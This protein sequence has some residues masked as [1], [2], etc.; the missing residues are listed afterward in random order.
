MNTDTHRATIFIGSSSEGGDIA[1]QLEHEAYD[2]C[3]VKKWNAGKVFTPGRST[4][5]SLVEASRE[6]DFAVLVATP[7]DVTEKRG[8]TQAS[9]RDNILL[10]YGLFVGALGRDRA[11]LLVTGEASLPTD[12]LGV[13]TLPW[14]PTRDDDHHAALTGTIIELKKLVKNPGPLRRG[15]ETKIFNPHRGFSF[16][17]AQPLGSSVKNPVDPNEFREILT[18]ELDLLKTSAEEQGWIV[19]KNSETTLRLESPRGKTYTLAK[20]TPEKTRDD[21]RGFVAG[22]RSDGLR[23]SGALRRPVAQ[24]PLHGS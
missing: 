23:I 19:R 10:E 24:S 2:F 14:R 18:K 8:T 13:T 9:I 20:S 6:V 4:L 1:G 3:D 12:V 5:E 11:F 17:P 21:L 16:Q 7:D 15:G 22:L